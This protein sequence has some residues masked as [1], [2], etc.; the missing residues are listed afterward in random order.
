MSGPEYEPRTKPRMKPPASPTQK[1]RNLY[2][3]GDESGETPPDKGENFQGLEP[4]G[5]KLRQW[6]GRREKH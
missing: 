4:L 5:R 1:L 6:N 3:S 2:T